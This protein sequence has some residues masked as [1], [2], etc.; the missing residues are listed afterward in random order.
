MNQHQFDAW[1]GKN[2]FLRYTLLWKREMVFQSESNCLPWSLKACREST[3]NTSLPTIVCELVTHPCFSEDAEQ[4]CSLPN[5][6]GNDNSSLKI[7]IIKEVKL[8]EL[9]SEAFA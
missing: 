4:R 9:D 5:P 7:A 6:I 1:V 2:V 8:I 3:I